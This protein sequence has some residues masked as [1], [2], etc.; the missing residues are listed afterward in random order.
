MTITIVTGRYEGFVATLFTVTS[1]DPL[2][3]GLR[4]LCTSFAA[5]VLATYFIPGCV[6]RGVR[7]GSENSSGAGAG[8]AAA[9][10]GVWKSGGHFSGKKKAPAATYPQVQG[11]HKYGGHFSGKKKRLRQ[12]SQPLGASKKPKKIKIVKIKIRSAQNVGKVW[13][14][15]KKN[16]PAPFGAIPGHFL[17]GPEKS[18]KCKKKSYFP[19]WALA[20]IHPWWGY[21]Y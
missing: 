3:V 2:H 12:R 17:R 16:L 7:L 21:W 11:F 18:K 5:R 6:G 14:S 19:W 1:S 8:G 10:G 13:I 15:R 9:G 4:I 20:A